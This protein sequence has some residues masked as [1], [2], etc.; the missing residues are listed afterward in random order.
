[1]AK[2]T[3]T[4]EAL[5]KSCDDAQRQL[6]AADMVL[7]A[8]CSNTA[9][10][11][12]TTVEMPDGEGTYRMRLFRI[13]SKRDPNEPS[14]HGGVVIIDGPDH[15]TCDNFEILHAY[16]TKQRAYS[17]SASVRIMHDGLD[18]LRVERNKLY[19]ARGFN[20]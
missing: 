18:H 2:R 11:V 17:T 6:S 16:F 20:C 8:L 15:L 10:D 3:I 13:W 9:P 12:E 14:D 1:M 19:R 4:R 7:R 5:E